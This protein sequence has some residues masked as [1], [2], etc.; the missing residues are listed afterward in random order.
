MKNLYCINNFINNKN[1]NSAEALYTQAVFVAYL[2]TSTGDAR[3][4]VTRMQD[5]IDLVDIYLHSLA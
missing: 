1:Y 5:Y 2:A 4:N 3:L